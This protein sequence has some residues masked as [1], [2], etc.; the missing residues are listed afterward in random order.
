MSDRECVPHHV[1]G[2]LGI[3]CAILPDII[4][5]FWMCALYSGAV[6]PAIALTGLG[7]NVMRVTAAD[8]TCLE[9]CNKC[10]LLRGLYAVC[11]VDASLLPMGK[12]GREL[13]MTQQPS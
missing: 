1:R 7:R 12:L 8:Q 5:R 9:I 13:P 10:F 3:G 11:P 4:Q 2:I 6:F